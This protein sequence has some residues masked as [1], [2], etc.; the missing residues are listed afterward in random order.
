M[1]LKGDIVATYL[2]DSPPTEIGLFPANVAE[3]QAVG[4]WWA[5]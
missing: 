1:H 4:L 2:A 5:N 3:Q